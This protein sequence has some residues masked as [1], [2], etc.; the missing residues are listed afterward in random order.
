RTVKLRKNG[1]KAIDAA[2]TMQLPTSSLRSIIRRQAV[3]RW[4]LPSVAAFTPTYIEMIL[5]GALAGNHVQQWEL[6]DLMLRTWPTL[7]TCKEEL[8]HG[9][10]RRELIFEPFSPEGEVATAGAIEREKLVTQAIRG[11]RPDATSDENDIE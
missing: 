5:Q 3:F 11:M 4:S 6:F 8:V 1:K 2:S 7:A 10:T 9:V